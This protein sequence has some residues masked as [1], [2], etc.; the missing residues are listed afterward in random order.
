MDDRPLTRKYARIERERRF[1]LDELPVS[2]GPSAFQRLRDR[3]VDGARLR[4]RRVESPDGSEI[5]TKLGQKLPNPDDPTN[6]CHQM[7]TTIYLTPGESEVLDGLPGRTS[8]KRRYKLAEQGWTFCIDVWEQ[9][10][11]VAGLI[12]AEV[13]CPTDDELDAI[14]APNWVVSEVTNDP[15]YS[16]Y[17]LAG[18]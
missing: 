17:V 7:M 10:D 18:R 2:V 16:A 12:L 15:Q 9:P 3:F 5:I 6:P 1:L 8:V 13:E 11:A 4:I 14:R